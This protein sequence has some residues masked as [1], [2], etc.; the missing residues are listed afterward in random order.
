[1]KKANIQKGDKVL[2]YGASGSIG[3]MT[4]QLAKNAGAVVTSVCSSKHFE[5]AKSLGKDQVIDYTTRNAKSQLATYKYVIDAVGNS[6]S[7]ALKE[8]SKKA[9]DPNGKYIS[10]DHGTPLTLKASFIELRNLAEQGKITLVI[11]K[12]FPL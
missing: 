6:K 10:I 12:V 7:S 4:I 11:D 3:T 8:H 9:L 2:V 1:M 5:S